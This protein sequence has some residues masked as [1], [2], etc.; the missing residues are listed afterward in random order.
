MK[1]TTSIAIGLIV[2]AA[3]LFGIQLLGKRS[4]AEVAR[5]DERAEPVERKTEDVVELAPAAVSSCGF[6]FVKVEK[7]DLRDALTVTAV[8]VPNADRLAHV[9]PRIRGR[10]EKIH[11][12]LGQPVKRGDILA[13]LDS[14]DLGTARAAY[15]KARANHESAKANFDREERLMARNGTT[16]KDHLEAKAALRTAEAELH[17][18]KETLLLYGVSA[19][20]I[21]TL[22]WEQKKPIGYFPIT[23]PFDGT[24]IEKHVT[25][26]E[27]VDT[28]NNLFTVADLSTVWII[29]DVYQKDL[30]WIHVGQ[31]VQGT[32]EGLEG[33]LSGKIS[34]VGDVVR[35]E[36]RTVEARVEVANPER[37]IK[38]GM[39][40]TAMVLDEDPEHARS[41][42][43]VP[44]GA[45]QR[46]D[47]QTV[48]FVRE[49]DE[50]T[51][52]RKLLITLGRR[53]G[54]WHE[55]IAGLSEGDEVVDKGSFVLKSE[56]QRHLMG[57]GHSH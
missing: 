44:V 54:D 48:V 26:G 46:I 6:T 47:G 43:A 51:H 11:A 19:E 25:V 23:A 3:A 10:V 27:V 15:L 42:L 2:G 1:T 34:N 53:F 5:K 18:A 55:V 21:A 24:I 13:E 57:E 8:V 33:T 22:S 41:A 28:S 7:R 9:T 39:F 49:K 38:P 32:A 50:P 30:G 4:A 56:F 45:V 31:R 36:T 12:V 37:R 29:L 52:F 20:D 14:V 40:V 17:A 35:A 16:E